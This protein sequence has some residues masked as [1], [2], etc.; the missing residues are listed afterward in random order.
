MLGLIFSSKLDWGSY[1]ISIA[2]TASKKI[3]ASIH[4]M[5]LLSP[6]LC[7]SIKLPYSHAW[8]TVVM[9]GLVLLVATWNCWI[10]YKNGCARLFGPSFAASLGP[11]FHPR[12]VASLSLFYRYCFGRCSSELVQLIPISYSPGRS[13]CYLIDCM[14]FLSPFLDV[15]RMPMSTV[16][17]LAK[18]HSGILCLYNAFL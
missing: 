12:N 2:K 17:F 9:S 11:L 1:I 14:I 10:K 7:L 3:G 5:K 13:T 18:L 4:S 16:Y 8:N 6:E 15:T